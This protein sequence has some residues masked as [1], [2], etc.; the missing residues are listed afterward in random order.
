MCWLFSVWSLVVC[1]QEKRPT[2]PPGPEW[3]GPVVTL[4]EENDDVAK[5]GDQ[6]PLVGEFKVG[7]VLA[8]KY[9]DLAL[10]YIELVRVIVEMLLPK[11]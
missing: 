10:S 8:F 9:C 2:I 7:G 1:A 3:N 11:P 5:N 4:I 6:Q